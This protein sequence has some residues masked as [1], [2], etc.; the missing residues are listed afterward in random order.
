MDTGA[1]QSVLREAAV[2]ALRIHAGGLYVDG[3]F[4]RGGHA[5]AV[6]DRLDPEGRLW[7]IDR[8]PEAIA[9]AHALHG[10][11]PR[12]HI[13]RTSFARAPE[14]LLEAGLRGRVDGVLLDLG[15]S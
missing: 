8:D 2:E 13:C 11:D 4:G 3:T 14:R 7:L 5:A 10:D 1:H 6:L 12:C 9:L 15:V